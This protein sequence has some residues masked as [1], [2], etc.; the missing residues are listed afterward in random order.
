MLCRSLNCYGISLSRIGNSI[1]I[2]LAATAVSVETRTHVGVA[3]PCHGKV[4]Y[5]IY[6]DERR[7][8]KLPLNSVECSQKRSHMGSEAAMRPDSFLDFGAIGQ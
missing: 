6:F 7:I 1:T 4:A 2:A 5:R 3:M 8:Q